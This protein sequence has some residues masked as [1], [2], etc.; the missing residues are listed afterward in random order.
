VALS[1]AQNGDVFNIVLATPAPASI[2]FI[3]FKKLTSEGENAS[4]VTR[5]APSSSDGGKYALFYSVGLIVHSRCDRET[6]QRIC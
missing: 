3:R 2:S 1:N 6:S 4:W 5:A